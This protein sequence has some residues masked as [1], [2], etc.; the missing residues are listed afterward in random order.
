MAA[1]DVVASDTCDT[2]EGLEG[3]AGGGGGGGCA[4]ASMLSS[5]FL[6]ERPAEEDLEERLGSSS[7]SPS[8]TD[9]GGGGSVAV[10]ATEALVM[11]SEPSKDAAPI[12][13]FPVIKA[14]SNS[15]ALP[16]VAPLEVDRMYGFS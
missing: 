10:L 16:N 14:L 3:T 6:L 8:T 12:D 9:G 15:D 2:M 4:A 5:L 1:V 7:A 13:G 11:K